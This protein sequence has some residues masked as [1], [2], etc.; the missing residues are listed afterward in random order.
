LLRASGR[1]SVSTWSES[2]LVRNLTQIGSPHSAPHR[3]Y[4]QL[5][6]VQL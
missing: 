5:P 2:F 6:N 1:Y 3:Y 4:Y